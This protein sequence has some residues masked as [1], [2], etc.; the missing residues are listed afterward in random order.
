MFSHVCVISC[1]LCWSQ[2]CSKGLIKLCFK[3][4]CKSCW[5]CHQIWVRFSLVL[6]TKLLENCSKTVRKHQ[7]QTGPHFVSFFIDLG[8]VSGAK[9]APRPPNLEPRWPQDP[10]TWSQDNP[11]TP[12]LE[13]KTTN[14]GPRPATWSQNLKTSQKL[15]PF[16]FHVWL[17]VGSFL[18]THPG[19]LHHISD[20]RHRPYGP[21]NVCH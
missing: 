1:F 15:F 13:A 5:L 21:Y 18:I 3:M 6:V 12:N 17:I 19:T 4:T 14:L 16:C 7:T 9:M 10:P 11:R 8:R 2:V 20:R